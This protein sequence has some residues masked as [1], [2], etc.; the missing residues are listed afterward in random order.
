MGSH[1]ALLEFFPQLAGAPENP[2]GLDLQHQ[3]GASKLY[4]IVR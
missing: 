1:Y 4:R 2:P 3:V